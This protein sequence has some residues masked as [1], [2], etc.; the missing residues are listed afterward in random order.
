MPEHKKKPVVSC[1][2]FDEEE[3]KTLLKEENKDV[4][5]AK[6]EPIRPL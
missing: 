2:K 1:E 4:E 3:K 6:V 5:E